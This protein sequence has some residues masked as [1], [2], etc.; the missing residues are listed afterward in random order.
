ME[1]LG[2]FGAAAWHAGEGGHV[3]DYDRGRVRNGLV[4]ARWPGAVLL[5]PRS[6][7]HGRAGQD[8]TRG[9]SSS[10]VRGHVHGARSIPPQSNPGAFGSVSRDGERIVFSVPPVPP[11]RQLTVFD[12]Q[13]KEVAASD[14]PASTCSRPYRLTDR[15]LP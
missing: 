15:R 4:A 8:R 5:R 6:R 2:S 11:L 9:R 7:G 14:F 12:R 1:I 13:G 10:A 3:A